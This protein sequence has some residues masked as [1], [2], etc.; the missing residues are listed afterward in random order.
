MA[1]IAM[2]D[3][4]AKETEESNTTV[5][6]FQQEID[7][8]TTRLDQSTDPAERAHLRAVIDAE[9]FAMKNHLMLI[10]HPC[11]NAK[12]DGLNLDILQR[13]RDKF[14][15]THGLTKFVVDKI[16]SR[17]ITGDSIME[18]KYGG[19]VCG[20]IV[21]RA[22]DPNLKDKNTLLAIGRSIMVP[23]RRLKRNKDQDR[24]LDTRDPLAKLRD[25]IG[26]S[27]GDLILEDYNQTG[28]RFRKGQNG[29]SF[30]YYVDG[31]FIENEKGQNK[32]TVLIPALSLM[33]AMVSFFYRFK[34]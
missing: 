27:S 13:A 5:E 12:V 29:A 17:A 2:A 4:D 23:K 30:V 19:Y 18:R 32:V 25:D 21:P 1:S 28:V 34:I 11:V 14:D 7:K 15:T 6:S 20:E 10:D 9:V 31:K 3:P 22:T 26:L 16:L 33:A 8:L 24:A